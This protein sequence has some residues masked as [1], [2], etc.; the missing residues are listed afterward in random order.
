MKV[1]LKIILTMALF[2]TSVPSF[3]VFYNIKT[4]GA[5]FSPDTTYAQLG[6]SIK[7]VI[8]I[9]HDD[10]EI[11]NDSYNTNVID[12]MPGGFNFTSGT[13]F[14]ELTEAKTFYFGCSYHLTSSQMKGVIIVTDPLGYESNGPSDDFS[15]WPNPTAGKIQIKNTVGDENYRVNV[16][17]LAGEIVLEF[18]ALSVNNN[19]VDLSNL[20]NGVY[21]V[22][23][24]TG[25]K[26]KR[27]RIIK[28]S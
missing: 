16:F 19:S 2:W 3:C 15:I 22:F 20:D 23:I 8:S 4:I 10:I 7:F 21:I 27:I 6:D 25:N 26:S 13:Y 17:N 9:G 18:S 5:T 24:Y 12:A 14:Y 1:Y 11:T 28:Q